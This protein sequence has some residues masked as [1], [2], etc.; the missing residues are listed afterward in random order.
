VIG[1][2]TA[3]AGRVF[4]VERTPVV[5]GQCIAGYDPR[6]IKG[7]G[8]TYA[9]SPM[10]ADHTAGHSADFPVD[11]HSPEGKVELSRQT[12]VT[13][14]AWDTLGLCS[15]VTGATA[16]QMHV[17]VDMLRALDG[18]DYPDNYVA[19]L[20]QAVLQMERAFNQ[21]AG[22]TPAQDR[23]IFDVRDEDLDK[24]FDFSQ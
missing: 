4:G 18:K 7:L 2:G 10:G 14:A 19:Q 3:T 11:H 5:K 22:F 21:V 12:Q 23:L 8:V 20:G 16:P 17:V 24:L 1:H 15:F 6:S 9:T 13:A